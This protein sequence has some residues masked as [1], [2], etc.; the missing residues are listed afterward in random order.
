MLSCEAKKVARAGKLRIYATPLKL[1]SGK[2]YG[3]FLV[4]TTLT[5]SV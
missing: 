5:D 4:F 2:V 1:V 3:L